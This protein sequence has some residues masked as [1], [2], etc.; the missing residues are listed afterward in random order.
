MRY[1]TTLDMALGDVCNVC[2]I[3]LLLYEQ[4]YHK[5]LNIYDSRINV[6]S[7]VLVLSKSLVFICEALKVKNNFFHE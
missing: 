6:K 1:G 4:F 7:K 5:Y 2:D 3:V